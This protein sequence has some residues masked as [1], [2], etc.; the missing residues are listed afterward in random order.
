MLINNI[1][2]YRKTE[3]PMSI[4][5]SQSKRSYMM[6]WK[7]TFF[8]LGLTTSQQLTDLVVEATYGDLIKVID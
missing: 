3:M 2:T 6:N 4:L 5:R 7:N 8:T 1:P